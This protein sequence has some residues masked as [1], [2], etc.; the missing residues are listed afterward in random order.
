MLST[1]CPD[2]SFLEAALAAEL[3]MDS[4][5]ET[6]S[7]D[8]SPPALNSSVPVPVAAG[9]AAKPS[10]L[11][12][13]LL[14]RKNDFGL[15]PP[16]QATEPTVRKV[17]PVQTARRESTGEDPRFSVDSLSKS[18]TVFSLLSTSNQNT[19]PLVSSRSFG[20]NSSRAAATSSRAPRR[21]R[22]GSPG[23]E[24]EFAL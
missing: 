14:R 9:S 1:S 13:G 24:L 7:A 10:G 20:K 17:S 4:K 16:P 21:S 11:T 3:R 2:V 12:Q 8:I 19:S 18:P 5:S 23:T 15:I 6:P 22:V